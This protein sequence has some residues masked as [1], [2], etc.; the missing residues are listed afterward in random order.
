MSHPAPIPPNA[1]GVYLVGE[2]EK[3]SDNVI[4]DAGHEAATLVKTKYG[5]LVYGCKTSWSKGILDIHWKVHPVD[6]KCPDGRGNI[7]VK[8]VP[9]GNKDT[10]WISCGSFVCPENGGKSNNEGDKNGL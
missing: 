6:W 8:I 4:I 1:F 3:L 5:N 9:K 7:F 10:V 2:K